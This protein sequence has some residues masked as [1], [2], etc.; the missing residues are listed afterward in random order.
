MN[1][2][3]RNTNFTDGE[4]SNIPNKRSKFSLGH[5]VK[6]TFNAGDIVPIDIIEVLPG[7]T[8]DM[9]LNYVCRLQTLAVPLMDT[10]YIETFS[11]YCPNRILWDNWE[12]F[13]GAI[14]DTK[15]EPTGSLTPPYINLKGA[16]IPNMSK[17]LLD[18]LGV[19]PTNIGTTVD[20]PV[21]A[22]PVRAY[23]QIWNNYFRDENLQDPILNTTDDT[24]YVYNKDKTYTGGK[25]LKA[26]KPH[27]YFTSCL[28]NSQRGTGVTIPLGDSARVYA[29]SNCWTDIQHM[30]NKYKN[31]I[32]FA[33]N[34]SDKLNNSING[35]FS[36]TPTTDTDSAG[37]LRGADNTTGISGSGVNLYPNNLYADLSAA[38]GVNV[39]DLRTSLIT[40]HVLEA[41]SSGGSRYN[42]LLNVL[43]GTN[44]SSSVIDRP[45]LIGYSK[46]NLTVHQVVQQSETENTPLGTT[47][48][49]SLSIEAKQGTIHKSFT[50]HGLIMT[51]AVARWRPSYQ[52]GLNRYFSKFSMFDYYSPLYNGIG[53]TPVY[54]QEIY[55]DGSE[56]DNLVFGYQE[57]FS[58]YRYIPDKCTGE[59]RSQYAQSLDIW[60]LGD[61]YSQ[62]PT[63]SSEWI[64]VDSSTLDRAISVSEK[65]SDQILLDLYV[66][67]TRTSLLEL[68]S[69]PGVDKV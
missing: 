53:N 51:V 6:T 27:D 41:L 21:L 13:L 11:F 39:Q 38:T 8:I 60:H 14:D 17:S 44:V 5:N 66:N 29:G 3:M 50:E 2:L 4:L 12:K 61:Y 7:D 54:N 58:D 25:L 37:M 28:P 31:N 52:Q 62:L 64:Q 15:W 43:Y 49:M 59:M 1:T 26:C 18:Y 46:N 68:Y 23:C 33:S 16:T 34:Y 65:V 55:M 69:I 47:A 22:F 56:H 48:A 24:N 9:D 10:V 42:E 45:E 35:I 63:L 30:D 32:K 57:A 20:K 67:C 19:P 40:Q 36:P